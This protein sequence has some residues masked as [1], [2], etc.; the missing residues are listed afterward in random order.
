VLR[1]GFEELGLRRVHASHLGNNPTSGKV[2]QKVGMSYEGTP[3]STTR[4]GVSTTI[5]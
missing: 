4:G 1:Y 3:R 2:L 5:A